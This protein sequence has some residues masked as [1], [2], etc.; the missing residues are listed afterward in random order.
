MKT[1][2]PLF[3]VIVIFF[4]TVSCLRSYAGEE[5]NQGFMMGSLSKENWSEEKNTISPG[6]YSVDIYVNK[7]WKGKYQLKIEGKERF[8]L[9]RDDVPSL[10]LKSDS[11]HA[12]NISGQWINLPDIV[13]GNEIRFRQDIFQLDITV[14]QAQIITHDR[15]W[16]PPALWDKGISGLFTNYNVIYSG[17]ND[18]NNQKTS[19]LYLTL[20]SGFN[21]AEW[22]LRDNSYYYRN[23]FHSGWINRSRYFEKS[24]PAMNATFRAGDDNTSS[25][26]FDSVRYRG[27]S[28]SKDLAMLPDSYRTYMPVVSGIA[29]TNAIVKVLQDDKIVFQ[30]SVPA[31]PFEFSDLMP[32]GSRS[33]LYLVIENTDGSKSTTVIPYSSSGNL[34]RSGSSDWMLYAG[35]FKSDSLLRNNAFFQAEYSRGINNYLTLVSGTI[36]GEDYQSALMGAGLLIPHLG[37]LSASHQ[38]TRASLTDD[39]LQGGKTRLS[40]NRHF[41]TRTSVTLAASHSERD[42]LTLSQSDTA[43]DYISDQIGYR[44]QEKNT[45]SLAIDQRL[46]AGY[47]NL[48]A[49]LF[50]TEYWN[51]SKVSRQ[52]SLGWSNTYHQI[53]WSV[54]GGKRIYTSVDNVQRYHRTAVYRDEKYASLNLSIPLSLFGRNG[55]I[56]AASSMQGDQYTASMGWNEKVSDTFRYSLS[57]NRRS[58]EGASSSAWFSSISPWTSLNGNLTQGESYTQYDL[59]AS[60]SLLLSRHGLLSSP[61]MGNHFVIID[62]PGVANAKVNGNPTIFTNSEGKALIPYATPWRKNTFYL[63]SESAGDIQGNIKKVAPW[64]GSISY[65]KYVTDTR[66]TFHLRA[67]HADGQPLTFGASLFDQKGDELGYVAQGG[68]IYVKADLLPDYILV[69]TDKAKSCVIRH[70]VLTGENICKDL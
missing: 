6:T 53:S 1:S 10:D 51:T 45:L 35:Q 5:F 65:V 52:L 16:M 33:D 43:A 12:Q 25:V 57:A 60:G 47:G 49:G 21:L 3:R 42:Y 32:T 44:A 9:Q 38:Y 50:A 55:T 39:N 62:A 36:V 40:L 69:R 68:F 61:L 37:T 64:K 26:W 70:A 54:N 31:G 63:T 29:E 48:N 23:T 56:S 67:S 24:F 30:Q 2:F 13:Q 34:L 19:N 28:L 15:N 66:K 17:G 8:L 18:R 41:T 20:N 7:E 22:H 11:D 59:G 14:P 58:Q 4:G 27:V 46:P